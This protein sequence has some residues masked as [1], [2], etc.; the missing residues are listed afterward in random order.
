MAA[1][2]SYRGRGAPK[3]GSLGFRGGAIRHELL[4]EVLGLTGSSGRGGYQQSYGPPAAVLS[5]CDN[6]AIHEWLR[7]VLRRDGNL[8]PRDRG[9][10]GLR[11]HQSKNPLL[12]RAN[13]P[14]E[15]G[16]YIQRACSHP[17]LIYDRPQSARSTRSWA[18]SIRCTSPSSRKKGLWPLLSSLATSSTLAETSYFLWR[19]MRPVYRLLRCNG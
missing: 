2:G 1:R 17:A 5:M 15:Q 13:I 10:D 6:L 8:P 3:G 9:R 18:P 7:S 14:G 16:P 19:S 12:Q 11:I 4:F